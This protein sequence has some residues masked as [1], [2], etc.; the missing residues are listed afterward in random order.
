MSKLIELGSCRKPHGIKGAFSFYLINSESS[1]L[2][3]GQKITLVPLD[4]KSSIREEGEEFEIETI[5]FGNKTIVRLKNIADRN[6]VENMIPFS[7]FIKREDL[8][9]L[10][11]DN[12][13]LN[14]LIGL[15]VKKS[16]SKDL[17]GE[18]V[19]IGTN[20]VQDILKINTSGKIIDILLVDAFVKEINWDEETVYIVM[21]E[22]I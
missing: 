17:V 12:F 2:K 14:D 21:P 18:V 1:S 10:E 20:G 13:Y 4:G 15:S 7:I 11:E 16:E 22:I 5:N 8:P 3:S 9:D 19:D 6:E